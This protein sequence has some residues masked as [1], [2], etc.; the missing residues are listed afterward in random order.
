MRLRL[1]W[2]SSWWLLLAA[3]AGEGTGTPTAVV[4]GPPVPLLRLA[5]AAETELGA[6]GEIL[7][8]ERETRA[9]VGAVNAA[10]VKS[11]LGRGLP[12]QPAP[13]DAEACF[14]SSALARGLHIA[15]IDSKVPALTAPLQST[16]HAGER[17]QLRPTDLLGQVDLEVIVNGP[18]PSIAALIDDVGQCTRVVAVR[19][20]KVNA[21]EAA[22]T[23]VAWFEHNLPA[24]ELEIRW[25]SLDERLLAAG[26]KPADPALAKDPLLPRLKAAVDA[27]REQLP[28]VRNILAITAE[29][30]RWMLRTKQLLILR[31]EVMRIQ[32]KLLLGLPG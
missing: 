11:G 26:W 1:L 15:R 7:G 19:H 2:M 28:K 9:S 21:N 10:L 24:P 23:A 25:R 18:L 3:C 30:P 32:G 14:R 31:D 29:I 27:G 8:T 13:E 6:M 16:L 4:K 12:V 5:E 22:L 20:V 17:W